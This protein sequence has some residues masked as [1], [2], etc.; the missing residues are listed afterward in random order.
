MGR[1]M[2]GRHDMR[3]RR[4]L[5]ATRCTGPS[6]SRVRPAA[7]APPAMP[8]VDASPAILGFALPAR[9]K[10]NELAQFAIALVEVHTGE[11]IMDVVNR[12][13]GGSPVLDR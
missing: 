8:V 11:R 13:P 10:R 4:I 9:V 3:L 12:F 6:R 5:G 7:S 1:A 2:P